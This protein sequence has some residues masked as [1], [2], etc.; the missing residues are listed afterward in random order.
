MGNALTTRRV[1]IVARWYPAHDDAARGAY[2][3]DLTRALTDAGEDV[4]VASF[5]PA[6]V[7]GEAATRPERARVAR[8]AWREAVARPDV[9]NT[10][11]SWGAP[12]VAVARLPVVLDSGERS[13][14]D[15]VAAH[16]DVLLAFGRTLAARAPFDVVHA[17]T[18]LPDG[19][20]AAGLAD[21]LGLPLVVTEHASLIREQLEDPVA[22]AM[23]GE[24]TVPGRR[25]VAVSDHLA[26]M[27]E[28]RLSLAPGSVAVVPNVV[29]LDVFAETGEP[30]A[31]GAAAGIELL[32]VGARKDTKGTAT[33]LRA[34]ALV[35]AARPDARLRMIG[36]A[37][38]ADDETRWHALAAELRVEDAVAFDPPVDRPGVARAMRRATLFVHPSPFETFGMV[39]AEALA[40]GLPVVATPSGVEAIVGTDGVCGE[41][42][43][44]H[45]PADLADAILR[46][47]DRRA[48]FDRG[49][50][51][52]RVVA[53]SGAEAVAA[54][55][56]AVYAAAAADAPPHG[57]HVAAPAAAGV[58]VPT[59]GAP[60][61]PAP[62]PASDVTVPTPASDVTV[63]AH[64]PAGRAVVVCLNRTVALRAIP[65]LPA[66]AL[67]TAVVVT[68]P[69]TRQAPDPAPGDGTWLEYD[70]AGEHRRRVAELTTQKDTGAAGR[71][72]ALGSSGARHRERDAIIADRDGWIDAAGRGTLA[73]ALESAADPGSAEPVVVAVEADD[74]SVAAPLLDAGAFLAPGALRWLADRADAG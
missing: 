3:A 33:L 71:L 73:R 62:T 68:G 32:W 65:R 55:T 14:A 37:P 31:S 16:A 6:L 50:M 21:A 26:R 34:F 38:T 17:H 8:D 39:A 19:L 44:S 41:I 2:V 9:L 60:E 49:A 70:P 1:L 48:S 52:A 11:R 51:R 67:A 25:L 27:L 54:A 53:R 20:A 56:L 36:K 40:V 22:A 15:E 7:R 24:L 74:V 64:Q 10:P 23:V 18:A 57:A 4:V 69:P 43:A 35:R 5:E 12:G 45:E 61:A 47:L 13:I 59:P 66:A 29:P 58:P 30:S 28:A 63:P 46:A 72:R 42:A